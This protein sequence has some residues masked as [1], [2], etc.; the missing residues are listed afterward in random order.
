MQANAP[1]IG[2]QFN[3]PV[4]GTQINEATAFQVRDNHDKTINNNPFR[5]AN[6]STNTDQVFF[7]NNNAT[8]DN[9]TPLLSQANQMMDERNTNNPAILNLQEQ[10]LWRN[11][12]LSLVEPDTPINHRGRSR[13]RR[14]PPFGITRRREDYARSRDRNYSGE[15]IRRSPSMK[16]KSR[17]GISDTAESFAKEKLVWP[18]KQLGFR[19]LQIQPTFDQLQFEHLVVGELS[20]IATCSSAFEA[21]HRIRLL[22]RVSYWKMRGAMWF[23]VR[24]FYAAVLSSIESHELDWDDSFAELEQM[25]ID[26]PTSKDVVKF[27]RKPKYNK[28]EDSVWFCKKFNTEIGCTLE[29]GHNIVTPRGDTKQALH[30]CARCFKNKKLRKDHSETS[31]QCPEKQ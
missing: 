9:V 5:M 12:A 20:T 8:S 19:F 30:I 1:L 18:Q 2:A 14:T 7:P 10:G 11:P 16:N 25:I 17:S 21:K 29:S 31:P 27:D 22:Q 13:E 3:A 28:K 6:N 24:N 23:Q 15:S 4:T 26:R